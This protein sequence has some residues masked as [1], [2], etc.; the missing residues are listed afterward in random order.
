MVVEEEDP[1]VIWFP[2]YTQVTI[3]IINTPE[4]DLKTRRTN[5]T[6]KGR[7]EDTTKKVGSMETHFGR[8][9]DHGCCSGERARVTEKGEKQTITPGGPQGEDQSL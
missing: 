3:K 5:S 4:I 1:T 2:E 6:T 7:E 9:T 8:E